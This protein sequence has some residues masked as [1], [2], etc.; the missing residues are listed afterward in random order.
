MKVLPLSEIKAI[1]DD[2]TPS[3]LLQCIEKA[4]TDYSGGK[5]NVPPVGHLGFTSPPGDV[6]IKYG[7]V[8]GDNYFVIKIASGFYQNQNLGLPNNNGMMLAFNAKTGMPECLLQDEGYLTD[9]RTALAGAVAAKH[10]APRKVE[11]IGILGTG[12]QARMQLELLQYVTDCKTVYVYGRSEE[13]QQR[14]AGEMEEKGFRVTCCENPKMVAANANLIV[15]TTAAQSP[16]LTAEDI[17]PGTHITAMGA[18]APG[19]Q[20]LEAE[21]LQKADLVA[22]DSQSQC[23]D[24]GE[25]HYAVKQ[26][27]MKPEQLK[28]IGEIIEN[29]YE[30][31]PDAITIADLTGIATQDIQI[32][33]FVLNHAS[34]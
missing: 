13:K 25:A 1:I 8:A 4:F 28:E 6:H 26:K 29:G 32:T 16:L 17:R 2:A 30:R 31:T 22:C 18:D 15:T 20:E 21:I 10:M 34:R 24:H 27:G 19:K 3:E 33:L 23:V 5:A 12:V 7:H 14:F 9:L 11:A